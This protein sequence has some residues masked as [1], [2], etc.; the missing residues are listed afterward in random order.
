M[1][2]ALVPQVVDLSISGAA[3]DA[4]QSF[5]TVGRFRILVCG[6]D[7]TVGWVLSLLDHA[8][9]ECTPPVA[10]LP[11]GTGN[12]LA[13]ALGWGGGSRQPARGMISVL[14]EVDS[15]QASAHRDTRRC[16]SWRTA[17]V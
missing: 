14:E 15:A 8:S 10:I 9:L 13:R 7:G 4:L 1:Y 11:L 6:G 17:A 3:E 5:R 12:D 2:L 16:N